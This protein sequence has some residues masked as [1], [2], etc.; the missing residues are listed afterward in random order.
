MGFRG[1]DMKVAN[2]VAELHYLVQKDCLLQQPK[3]S[4]AG[5]LLEK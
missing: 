5:K 4:C 3:S 1:K 2:L